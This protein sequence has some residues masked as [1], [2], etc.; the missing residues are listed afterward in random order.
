[1]KVCVDLVMMVSICCGY[2]VVVDMVMLLLML[3]LNRIILFIV[4]CCRIVDSDVGV[5]V[6]M[7]FSVS[8]FVF[9]EDCLK[10]V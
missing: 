5:L 7:K 10:F 2:C 9:V 4:K 1:M 8:L 3:W 6:E